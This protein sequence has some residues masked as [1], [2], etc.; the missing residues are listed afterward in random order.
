MVIISSKLFHTMKQ[1]EKYANLALN[2]NQSPSHVR[3][4]HHFSSAVVGIVY[5]HF[6]TQDGSLKPKFGRKMALIDKLYY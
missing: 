4:I 2:N 5:K 1:L 3:C 6:D